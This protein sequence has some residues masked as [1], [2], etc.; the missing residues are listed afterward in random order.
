MTSHFAQT[1]PSYPGVAG[2]SHRGPVRA[3][4]AEEKATRSYRRAP[5][6][7]LHQHRVR[8][9]AGIRA[10]LEHGAPETDEDRDR[11]GDRRER[12]RATGSGYAPHHDREGGEQCAPDD[13]ALP[14]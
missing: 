3:A 10:E 2:T 1:A 9:P 12:P 4:T 11:D 5:R 14:G 8:V 6:G 13:E 7:S